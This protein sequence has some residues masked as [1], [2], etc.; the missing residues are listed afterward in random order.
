MSAAP[1]LRI[2]FFV[3]LP[4][5]VGLGQNS[6]STVLDDNTPIRGWEALDPP[7][8]EPKIWRTNILADSLQLKAT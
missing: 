6:T 3:A 5:D 4:F 8:R 7:T 2:S 1:V